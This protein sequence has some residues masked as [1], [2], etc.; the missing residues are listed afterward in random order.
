[1]VTRLLGSEEILN[2]KKLDSMFNARSIAVVGASNTVGKVGYTIL[3]NLID[4]G[5]R[6]EIYP[7]NPKDSEVQGYRAYKKLN[8]VE[9]DIDLAVIAIPSK[10]VPAS[11]KEAGEKAIKNIIIITGGFRE[12]GKDELEN[13]DLDLLYTISNKIRE[14][15]LESVAQLVL[16]KNKTDNSLSILYEKWFSVV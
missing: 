5:F 4:G 13:G 7:I 2:E 11:V 6:G 3:K 15:E 16:K 14:N 1:M 12:I 8:E 10:L 9:H